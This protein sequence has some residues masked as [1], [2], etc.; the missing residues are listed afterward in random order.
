[1][2]KKGELSVG[3]SVGFGAVK[4]EQ[5]YKTDQHIAPVIR[6]GVSYRFAISVVSNISFQYSFSSQLPERLYFHPLYLLSGQ[7]SIL[8]PAE[9]LVNR[10]NHLISFS[11]A[12]HNLIKN[13]GFVFYTSFSHTDAAYSY[14]SSLT[15][16]YRFLYFLSQNGNQIG[17]AN[18]KFEKFIS[19]IKTK[20]SVQLSAV[21]SASD[22]FF[23]EVLSRNSMKNFSIQPKVVTAFKF[24]VNLEASIT[25]MYVLN[26]TI[27]E[28]GTISRFNLWQYQGYGKVK[29]RAGEKIYLAAIYNYY[30]LSPQNFFNTMDLYANFSLN[31]AWIFSATVHNLFNAS[32]IVQRQFSVNSVSEQ[33]FELVD[34]YL[35][36]KAQWSF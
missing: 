7:A 26:K 35:M 17:T 21:V 4:I 13:S 34:R 27:P 25:A 29:I 16:S 22:L 31:K 1:M 19:R 2:H 30:L 5:D 9:Q 14:S 32:S 10:R 8:N 6:G 11:Y 33:R 15:P 12:T 24:P 3:G 36:I 18:L 28:T 23:N 20:I